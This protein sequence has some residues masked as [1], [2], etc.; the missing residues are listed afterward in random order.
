MR[1]RT[2]LTVLL[3]AIVAM[4]CVAVSIVVYLAPQVFQNGASHPSQDAVNHLQP[5]RSARGGAESD[6]STKKPALTKGTNSSLLPSEP[7]LNSK[8]RPTVQAEGATFPVDLP[9]L[10]TQEE[11]TKRLIRSSAMRTW[12]SQDAVISKWP[13]YSEVSEELRSELEKAFDVKKA[14]ADF[15]LEQAEGF[16]DRFWEQGGGRSSHAYV[17]A[18]KA[19]IL[20][21]LAYRLKPGDSRIADELVETIQVT[22]P[23]VAFEQGTGKKTRNVEVEKLL[24]EL[25]ADQFKRTREEVAGGRKPTWADFIQAVDLSVLLSHYDGT[26]AREV[27][28]W[29]RD[30]AVRAEWTACSR[31][32]DRFAHNLNEGRAFNFNIYIPT[33]AK[34]P[35]EFQYG[36][37]LPSFRGPRPKE[38]GLVLWPKDRSDAN[39]TGHGG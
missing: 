36:R 2:R 1:N 26:S 23:L 19:R 9:Q 11:I 15:L 28:D 7:S 3:A 35:E 29:L 22:H 13:L 21:E 20:L 25:R 38:R 12:M 33:K 17:N 24:I 27:V 32:L 5:H 14:S 30:N 31:V 18:Y 34:Y 6:V 8:S 4:T 39:T 37:R 16:R 10:Y